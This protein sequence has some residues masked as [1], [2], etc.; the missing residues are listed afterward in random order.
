MPEFRMANPPVPAVPKPIQSESK[1]GIP[2]K[3]KTTIMIIV[4]TKYIL[5]KAF[6]VSA[7]LGTILDTSG[8]GDSAFIISIL[9]PP[10]SGK[11]VRTRT[12]T[13]IP[14]I[15]W[16]KERQNNRPF[17]SASTSER[18]EE[19]VVVKPETISKTASM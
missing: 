7:T 13:P 14:P 11:T 19:P 4:I 8:P 9:Y 18:T 6:A 15:Q 12:R 2:D 3:R 10:P 17:P 1:S 16:E 5:Y